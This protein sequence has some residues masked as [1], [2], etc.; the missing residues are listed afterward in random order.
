MKF[1]L[2][3]VVGAALLFSSCNGQLGG[4]SPGANA[5]SRNSVGG[6]CSSPVHFDEHKSQHP[7]P[8]V[9]LSQVVDGAAGYYHA[10][11]VHYFLDYHDVR[12]SK[13]IYPEK[14]HN[15]YHAASQ[16]VKTLSA[17][18]TAASAPTPELL[19]ISMKCQ[20]GNNGVGQLD[21]SLPLMEKLDRSGK[22]SNEVRADHV[23]IS[24]GTATH[25][26][27][28][29]LANESAQDYL[30]RTME[31]PDGYAPAAA[32]EFKMVRRYHDPKR[33]PKPNE[34]DDF[35]LLSRS[36]FVK[37]DGTSTLTVERSV[38]YHFTPT[39]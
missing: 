4:S 37:T 3:S 30:A 8:V 38:S 16:R 15:F 21:A 23:A 12:V 7:A 33:P 13:P 36:N 5:N 19:N 34:K 9:P 29:Y 10:V 24:G 39:P 2:I 1:I 31:S 27:H 6:T 22:E 35:Q 28:G 32:T 11:Q 18:S 25:V 17:S 20:S 26:Y 14:M